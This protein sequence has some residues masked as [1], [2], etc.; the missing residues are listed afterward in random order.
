MGPTQQRVLLLTW[1]S[2]EVFVTVESTQLGSVYATSLNICLQISISL[3]KKLD[4]LSSN[5]PMGRSQDHQDWRS[6]ASCE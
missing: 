1:L 5:F 3:A 6:K 2:L 4:Y